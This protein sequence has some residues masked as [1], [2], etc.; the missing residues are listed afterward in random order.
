MTQHGSM[1]SYKI[2]KVSVNQ[3]SS[4]FY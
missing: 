1:A 4:Y 3:T 2:L